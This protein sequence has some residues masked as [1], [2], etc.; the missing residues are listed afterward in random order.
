MYHPW[1]LKEYRHVVAILCGDTAQVDQSHVNTNHFLQVLQACVKSGKNEADVPMVAGEPENMTD[2]LTSHIS[3]SGLGSITYAELLAVVMN[4]SDWMPA[5]HARLAKV[6]RS[7]QFPIFDKNGK[8]E[9]IAT[10]VT[11]EDRRSPLIAMLADLGDQRFDAAKTSLGKYWRREW[12][13]FSDTNFS[14]RLWF[15]HPWAAKGVLDKEFSTWYGGENKPFDG[16]V[17]TAFL[18]GE[19]R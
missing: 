16:E 8:I 14:G 3:I 19:W 9:R 15:R 1:R 18:R 13:G 11:H 4:R 6:E 2:R 17:D 7:I 12:A 10:R 5:I